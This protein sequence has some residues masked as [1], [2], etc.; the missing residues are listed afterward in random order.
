[1]DKRDKCLNSLKEKDD[2]SPSNLQAT[3]ASKEMIS[4]V[5][6]LLEKD[7]EY[8]IRLSEIPK[9]KNSKEFDLTPALSHKMKKSWLNLEDL[10]KEFT[11][12]SYLAHIYFKN[13]EKTFREADQYYRESRRLYN[14]IVHSFSEEEIE[15]VS[16]YILDTSF[17]KEETLK[18]YYLSNLTHE[19]V[20]R[21]FLKANDEPE[22]IIIK[23]IIGLQEEL[24]TQEKVH[25]FP[26]I[27]DFLGE[28]LAYSKETKNKEL[29]LWIANKFYK[30]YKFVFPDLD[31][32]KES[33]TLDLCEAITILLK[34]TKNKELLTEYNS[35]LHSST[36][37]LLSYLESKK[38]MDKFY[39]V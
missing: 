9:L 20:V 1:M 18:Y 5:A 10:I 39:L 15:K 14:K 27:W 21:D 32:E 16:A 23:V 33:L 36:K 6:T 26:I 4:K 31:K 22:V 17:Y 8:N 24:L 2:K 11:S 12:L 25:F 13:G 37:L 29:K 38:G 19:K 3:I 34:Y 28:L 35:T 7:E 30:F